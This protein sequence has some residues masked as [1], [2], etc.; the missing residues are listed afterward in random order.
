VRGSDLDL[1]HL[2]GTELN[3]HLAQVGA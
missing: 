3:R 2:T 1:R